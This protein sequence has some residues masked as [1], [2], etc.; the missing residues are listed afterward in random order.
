MADTD[1][2]LEAALPLE[3]SRTHFSGYRLGRWFGR[4]WVSTL[5]ERLEVDGSGASYVSAD[6]TLQHFPHP[7]AGSWV[8]SEDGPSRSLGRAD[9][10][11]YLL[12]DAQRSC[13]LYFAPGA[14]VRPLA[15]I[16]DHNGN[17]IEFSRD[18][19]GVPT[20]IRHTGG[21]LVRVESSDD[22]ITA[23]RSVGADGSEVELMRYGYT[24]GRLTQVI[25]ASGQPMRFEYDA[26]GR[27]VSWTDR[28]GEW[29]RYTYD[30]TGRCVRT[31]GSG[32]FLSGTM[33]YD[34]ATRITY[35]TN[36][37]GHRTAFHMNEAGQVVREVDP[38]GNVTESEWDVHDRLL[39]RTD[40]IGRTVRYD[41]DSAG[42]VTAITRP[43]GSTLRR[44][45]NALGLPTVLREA[46]GAVTRREYDERG[47]LVKEADAAEAATMFAYDERGN[48]VSI[49]DAHGGIT[50]VESGI[51]GLVASVTD[52]MGAVTRYERDQFGRV[53]A[54]VDPA[55][56]VQR[57]GYTVSG[58][59][60]WSQDPDGNVQRWAFDGEGNE[61]A[62]SDQQATVH[63][64]Y[65]HFDLIKAE[66]RPDGTRLE[67]TYD[68]EM[69]L[70]G[71]TNEQGLVWRYDYDSAGN[72]V[73]E[74]DFNGAT[75]SYRYDAA[76]Q[77]VE[78]VNAMGETTEFGYDPLGN[79]VQR[80][81]GT[82]MTSFTFNAGG[83]LLEAVNEDSRLTYTYDDLGR[84]TSESVNGRVV[85]SSYDALGRRVRRSTPSGV[86]SVW[87]Y[88]ANGQ[89]TGLHVAG[90]TLAFEYDKLGRE[91]GR[92]LGS[93]AII[94]QEWTASGLLR[95]QA[96]TNASGQRSQQR[97]FRYRA[98]GRLIEVDDMVA[99]SRRF[100]LDGRG[101]V[102][103]VQA[104]GW[105]ERYAYDPAGNISSA[106]WPTATD[107]DAL[108]E[109]AYTGTL[110]R[111][112][113]A[114]RYEHDAQ[115]R[116]VV[117]Q[118]KRL[119]QGVETW[120]YSWDAD[121]RL[122]AVGM[123]DGTQWR[124]RYDA[125]GRRISKEHLAA[126]GNV[127]AR[128]DFTWDDDV[129][130]E[131]AQFDTRGTRVTVWDYEPGSY[132]PLI[133]S[134]RISQASREW[135]DG[136]FYAIVT[137]LVGAPAEL[138]DDDG[139]IA[140]FSRASLWG[141]ADDD[142]R[143]SVG[144]PLRFPGQYFDPE[145]G[146][147]YNFFRYY[148]PVIGRFASPDPIGLSGGLN[149]HAYVSNPT[150]LLDPLGLAPTKCTEEQKRRTQGDHARARNA[151]PEIAA[152][153]REKHRRTDHHIFNGESTTDGRTPTGLHAYSPQQRLNGRPGLPQEIH[154]QGNVVGRENKVHE[155]GP[156]RRD[157][158]PNQKD[159]STMFPK[160]W[161]QDDVRAY[162][163]VSE[164]RS[165]YQDLLTKH[166]TGPEAV[167]SA[168]TH[169]MNVNL[170][171]D[172]ITVYPS[173]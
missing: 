34:T 156:Y 88:D 96:V 90:R 138:V 131:Q 6:G 167:K 61:R 125:L 141:R 153:F 108:G 49:T 150:T 24:D 15:A 22:R 55:G 32:G 35:H 13:V 91:I 166:G 73:R 9:D 120:R 44:E 118:R 102:T 93:G 133:Q 63:R 71:V 161:S 81:C 97:S 31:E 46:D 122:V 45:Y 76:G 124:Y 10:G 33:E 82:A 80:R 69:R 58:Q 25:N 1:A 75:V 117:R 23:L 162:V 109:R 119:T 87:E 52:A 94:N 29:Y 158:V 116:M 160:N 105:A 126:L 84:V 26:D 145:T 136:Q 42:N 163:A 8:H 123:P 171:R 2:R 128:M 95:S 135:V 152:R 170:V 155:L 164:F 77:L 98:D 151:I 17:R 64:E 149:H 169:G 39:R 100:A 18:D 66:I 59:V 83:L 67:F 78:R 137:D 143:N 121:D 154:P 74:T 51:D 86:E 70:V 38:L 37:L 173:R 106:A 132:R 103:G 3:I 110:I 27:I 43:D 147:H 159:Q 104:A 114:I 129:L 54:I 139:A 50:R 79:V 14:G 165:E 101:R 111:S 172:G 62:H 146:L 60:A 107:Q 115:G 72:L 134:E 57:L 65:T 11:G 47:N 16:F 7:V 92:R 28:N 168:I 99:G 140:W 48:L 30:A 20:E 130:V 112:A 68:T 53:V 21:Y 127:M 148:D 144:M 142:A 89:P 19:S 12:E 113:G 40:Q 41:Y 157:G 85:R 5:D 4:E 36:S 56:A